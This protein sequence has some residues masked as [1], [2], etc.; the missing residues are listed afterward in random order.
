MLKVHVGLTTWFNEKLMFTIAARH[1]EGP[2]P[3]LGV[4]NLING[5]LGQ[6]KFPGY[7]NGVIRVF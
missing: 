5:D 4:V 1:A 2:G 3:Y 6:T 7:Y